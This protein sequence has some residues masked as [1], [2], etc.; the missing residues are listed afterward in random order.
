VA[1]VP[2]S[3]AC[4]HNFAFNGGFAALATGAEQLVE[5]QMAVES[6]NPIIILWVVRTSFVSA[7]YRLLIEGNAFK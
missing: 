6:R 1:N 3:T 7:C 5:I 2:F 4:D